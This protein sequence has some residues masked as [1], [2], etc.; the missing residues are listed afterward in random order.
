MDWRRVNSSGGLIMKDE[1]SS[2]T[3]EINKNDSM[4]ILL[5]KVIKLSEFDYT[6]IDNGIINYKFELDG[7]KNIHVRKMCK[8]IAKNMD[9]K[10]L[11]DILDLLLFYI[12][13]KREALILRNPEK[14]NEI[15]ELSILLDEFSD[16]ETSKKQKTNNISINT[17]NGTN[18][19]VVLLTHSCHL[20]CEYCKVKKYNANINEETLYKSIDLLFSSSKRDLQLQFF[21]GEPLMKFNLIM[22][23]VSYAEKLR[24]ETGKNIQ[25]VLTTNGI[26]LTKEKLDYFK[27]HNFII[28][29]SFDGD[30]ETQL[31][32]R[33]SVSG[34]NYYSI[35]EEN[36][37]KLNESGIQYYTISVVMP[38]DVSKLYENIIHLARKGHK[39]IQINYSLGFFWDSISVID[40]ISQI[41]R[42]M[43]Y[44]KNDNELD[45]TLV[46]TRTRREPV[47]LNAEL[48]VD[49]DGTI[50][51]E[52]GIC[53][54]EDFFKMRENF[55]VG[56]IFIDKN[57]N[58]ISTTRFGNFKRLVDAYAE[59]NPQ[60][61]SI[62]INNIELGAYL[63]KI[64]K[65][66]TQLGGINND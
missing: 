27:K 40:L 46:N 21:G 36:L 64:L 34:R 9:R 16:H 30:I 43:N 66:S 65:G 56:N 38:K 37:K 3:L 4:K 28:E 32:N 41:G 20:N 15:K 59:N 47:V 60:F 44:I 53:L 11:I 18:R 13:Y 50:F 58:Q 45:I 1:N 22:S 61:R 48:T 33:K 23:A 49:C 35:V 17:C 24:K 26:E 31:K 55:K 6:N 62:I 57:I 52:S 42:V 29:F 39:R 54:E 2:R 10:P 12:L 19:L 14:T 63:D 51:L 5:E 8:I 7:I 25:F